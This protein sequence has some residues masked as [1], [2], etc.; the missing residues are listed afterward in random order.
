MNTKYRES[1][2]A[3]LGKAFPSLILKLRILLY[4]IK[5]AM[6][7]GHFREAFFFPNVKRGHDIAKTKQLILSDHFREAFLFPVVERRDAVTSK[8]KRLCYPTTLGSLFL[9]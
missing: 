1:Y 6:L 9:C 2:Q 3:T 5:Q 4:Q 8:Q 7:L